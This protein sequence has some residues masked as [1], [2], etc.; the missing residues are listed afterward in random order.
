MLSYLHRFLLAALFLLLAILD[1]V[2][3]TSKQKPTPKQ[4]AQWVEQLGDND[5]KV[6]ENASKKLWQAGAA[7]E[8]S[9]E[10]AANS[11]DR[12][13][14]RRAR[15]LLDKF[16]WGIYPDTPANIVAL[17]R[18]YQSSAGIPR[19]EVLHK[20]LDSGDA[21]LRA[22][23]KIAA[24]ETDA[25]QRNMLGDAIANRLPAAFFLAV[26]EDKH[27]FFQHLLEVSHEGKFVSHNQYAAY[28]LLRGK[29]PE[30][31][32][33]F[34]ARRNA[35]PEDKWL[36][37]TLVYL[38]RANGDLV[39]ARNEAQKCGRPDLLEDILVELG[40]WRALAEISH[41]ALAEKS[42]KERV[43][44]TA[45]RWAFRA[46]FARLAGKQ[47]EFENA[48]HELGRFVGNRAQPL[49]PAKGLLLND[50]PAEGLDMLRTVPKHRD[51]L[52][53]ILR[54]RLE[55]G[56]ALGLAEKDEIPSSDD[57]WDNPN[58]YLARARLLC[59][60]GEKEGE[61]LFDRYAERIK[62]EIDPGWVENLLTE[63]MRAGLRDRAFTH[64]VK[65]LSVAP[66]KD[67]SKLWREDGEHRYFAAL[68]PQHAKTAEVWWTIL[69]RQ[70]KDE[71]P[72]A[73]MK[74]LRQLLEGKAV[75]KDVKKWIENDPGY[76]EPVPSDNVPMG[77]MQAW[78]QSL[79]EGALLAGLDDLAFSLLEKTKSRDAL[80]RMGDLLAAKKQWAKAAERY[81]QAWEQQLLAGNA[82]VKRQ[83]SETE[84][85]GPYDPLPLFLAGDALVHA[86]QEKEGKKLIEQAHWLPFAGAEARKGFLNAL[87]KRGHEKAA[88]RETELLLRVSEPNSLNSAPAIRRFAHAAIARK[89]YLHGAEGIE[90]SILLCL[91][92]NIN[93]IVNA[94]YVNVP[95]Q[96]HQFRAAGLLAAG[97]LDEALKQIDLGF[98]AS[99]G[100]V[101]LPLMLVPEL[102]RRGYK[103]E[104]TDLFNRYYAAYEKVCRDFPRCAS[105]HNEVAWISACSRRNLDKA[106]EHAQKAIELVP[107]HAGYH[108]TLAEVHFQRGDK[109]RAI[110]MQKRA[111]ELDP[112]RVYFRKQLKR[113]EAGDPSVKR[114]L[115][116]DD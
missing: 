96:I 66:P 68:F 28:W 43:D 54:A 4:I 90:Q 70:F 7:A 88:L 95:A 92:S 72:A 41:K 113:L 1:S 76:R 69:R 103:K 42:D 104:S 107:T 19:I 53:D 82:R 71:T 27:E 57:H 115:E 75:A 18:A 106:L 36:A 79:A 45:E 84:A 60:L 56:A 74:R 109:E 23:L 62:D 26:T 47:K 15:E 59:F 20:L 39:A 111:I 8:S 58:L 13:V 98:A 40:D 64:A 81:R 22:V 105:A 91:N 33:H 29:L 85:G 73:V 94:A 12:E 49:M 112:K 63:E 34:T 102:E 37:E 65:A 3:D 5:F 77:Q 38:H 110:A 86:G 44:N 61:A 10:K 46:A 31:I 89:D 2:A 97:K 9:L 24:A 48:V 83:N 35:H 101:D 100:F 11:V 6:R 32:A 52:F 16:R 51:V 87:A 17:I 78:R 80:L 116:N 30:R 114:P 108:D 55:F 99:P 67:G 50:R 21:G 25:N 14:V 93:F